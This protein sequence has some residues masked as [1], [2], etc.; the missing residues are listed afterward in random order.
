MCNVRKK[1]KASSFTFLKNCKI[2][3]F[4]SQ[5]YLSKL[6]KNICKNCRMYKYADKSC[7]TSEIEIKAHHSLLLRYILHWLQ[8]ISGY[9]TFKRYPSKRKYKISVD[10]SVSKDIQAR[11]NMQKLNILEFCQHQFLFTC[12][13][14]CSFRVSKV[15]SSR[16]SL[17]ANECWNECRD[18][19]F[20]NWE[21]IQK[22]TTPKLK[23][24][25]KL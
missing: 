7:A 22:Q 19:W 11:E 9:I 2:Y 15:I 24:I 18:K 3:L 16:A 20:W 17:Q 6:Q 13:T 21:A 23:L 4:Q 5:I 8:N 1:E 10:I 14:P 25:L 12:I